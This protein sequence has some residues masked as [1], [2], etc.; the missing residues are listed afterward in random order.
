MNLVLLS[1][2]F[3]SQSPELRFIALELC[4]TAPYSG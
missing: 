2:E 4:I 3:Y 1:N